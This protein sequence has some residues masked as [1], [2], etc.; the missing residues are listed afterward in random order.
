MPK[1]GAPPTRKLR[2]NTV[3]F[4]LQ[5]PF[6]PS[7]HGDNQY[8]A[9]F[10]ILMGEKRRIHLEFLKMKADFPD[11]LELCLNTLEDP[12]R[13]Q[14]YTDNENVLNSGT[15][16][17]ILKDRRMAPMNN[18]CEYEPWQNPAEGPWKT[19]TAASRQ[20]LLRSFGDDNPCLLYTSPSPRD[21]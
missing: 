12:A 20:F 1:A 19:L 8:V 16:M 6:P 4:D 10:I 7:A 18:N 14:L 5:G 3:C 13:M 21:S 17:K 15:V 11:H 2:H 9:G